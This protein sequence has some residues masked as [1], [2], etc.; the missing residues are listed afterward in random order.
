LKPIKHIVI[1]GGGTAGWMAAAALSRLRSGRDIAITVI[2]SEMIG[3]VGV[4]EATIPPFVEFNRL[5]EIDEAEML[6]AVHGSFKVGI[7]FQNWGQVGESYIHP[8]GSY[9]YELHGVTF[10]HVWHRYRQ[11]GDRRPIQVFNLETMAAH[12][13]KFSRTEDYARDDLPP[14]N[15]AYH[16]NA[17]LYAKFLRTYAEKRGAVRQEGK[18][19]DAAL[20]GETGFVTTLTLESGAKLSGDLFID[21]SG[22]RGLLIE[23]ALKTGYDDWRNFLPCDRAVAIPCPRADGSDPMPY[24]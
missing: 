5:L 8:F 13:G 12:F 3:T 18:V 9:G 1:V 23:Q 10:P 4:G 16:L 7:Q 6:S 20:D 2:E 15:Y 21:C 11:E 14:T 17:G 19:V 22:F 24:T